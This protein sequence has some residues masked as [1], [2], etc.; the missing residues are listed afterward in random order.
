MTEIHQ[1]EQS[2]TFDPN[3]KKALVLRSALSRTS[4]SCLAS[5]AED[6]EWEENQMYKLSA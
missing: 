6:A 3:D 5:A 2:F 1:K 4:A